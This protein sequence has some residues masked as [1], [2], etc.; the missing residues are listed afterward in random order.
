MYPVYAFLGAAVVVGAVV[1]LFMRMLARVLLEGVLGVR[2]V[3]RGDEDYR[4]S[5]KRIKEKSVQVKQE[6]AKGKRKLADR[7]R[8]YW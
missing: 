6:D 3:G 4:P 5:Q 2:L 7:K 1:G 8:V